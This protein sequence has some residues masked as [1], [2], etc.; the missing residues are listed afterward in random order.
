MNDYVLR[1]VISLTLR[2]VS[3]HRAE[4]T[5]GQL[6]ICQCVSQ[7]DWSSFTAVVPKLCYAYH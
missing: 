7:H 1:A 3:S 5:V 2:A 6:C 4:S